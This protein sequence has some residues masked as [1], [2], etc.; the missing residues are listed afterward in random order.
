[1][2][3]RIQVSFKNTLT[4]QDDWLD[5]TKYLTN[6]ADGG[7][8]LPAGFS[9]YGVYPDDTL[10]ADVQGGH[11]YDLR[12]AVVQA[13]YDLQNQ[14]RAKEES[15]ANGGENESS[16]GN[17]LELLKQRAEDVKNFFDGRIHAM[18][19]INGEASDTNPV[20]DTGTDIRVMMEYRYTSRNA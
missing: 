4:Q 14:V 19:I 17:D 16:A 18:R 15:I 10:S 6:T 11:W 20:T 7:F 1:M 5:I 12:S 8:D 9:N 3:V 2:G 13:A